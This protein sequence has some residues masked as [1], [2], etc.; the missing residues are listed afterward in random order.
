[1][2]LIREM[3]RSGGIIHSFLLAIFGF[4]PLGHLSANRLCFDN[5]ATWNMR[6]KGQGDYLSRLDQVA[7]VD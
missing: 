5:R 2:G 4:I 3:Q 1:M 6:E 7:F